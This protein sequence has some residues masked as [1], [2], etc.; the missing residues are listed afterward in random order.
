MQH[1]AAF[2]GQTSR[3]AQQAR[4]L[5][6]MAAGMAGALRSRH[7]AARMLLARLA[8]WSTQVSARSILEMLWVLSGSVYLHSHLRIGVPHGQKVHAKT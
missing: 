6:R 3:R 1:L 4:P 7:T 2:H 8:E 5:G